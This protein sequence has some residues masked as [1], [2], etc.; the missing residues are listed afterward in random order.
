MEDLLRLIGWLVANDSAGFIKNEEVVFQENFIGGGVSL[1]NI[2]NDIGN[3]TAPDVYDVANAVNGIVQDGVVNSD[4][5]AAVFDVAADALLALTAAMAGGVY[6]GD[7]FNKIFQHFSGDSF[8]SWLYGKQNKDGDFIKL[9]SLSKSKSHQCFRNS[10]FNRG[11]DPLV[12]DL[13]GNG[14]RTVGSD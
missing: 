11:W 3:G 10:V 2:I 4:V 13:T 1:A 7:A 5:A 14:I 9:T 8:G 6:V 12:I